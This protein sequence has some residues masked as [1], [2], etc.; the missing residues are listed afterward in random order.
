MKIRITRLPHGKDLPLPQ[1]ETPGAVGFDFVAAKDTEIPPR[2]IAR[3]STGLVISTPANHALIIAPRSS[4]PKKKHLD[5]PHSIGIIDQDYCGPQDE[6]LIQV[7]NFSDETV[8]VKRG[9]K[10][11]QGMFVKI[12]KAIWE[13]MEH[14]EIEANTRGGFGSTG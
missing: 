5:M 1:F 4:T 13:E 6:I 9:E 2:E 12:E 10:I 8:W 14:H 7:R 3:I 11:A